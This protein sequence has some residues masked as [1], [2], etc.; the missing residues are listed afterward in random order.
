HPLSSRGVPHRSDLRAAA[1]TRLGG[2][3]VA[4]GGR[5]WVPL[6]SPV[7]ARTIPG[8][9]AN[10]SG[11]RRVHARAKGSVGAVP[12]HALHARVDAGRR[13]RSLRPVMATQH[14]LG[15]RMRW[16]LWSLVGVKLSATS[17]EA[18]CVLDKYF[19]LY[20]FADCTV[21]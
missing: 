15:G 14:Q 2:A 11:V 5:G 4:P 13:T 10:R 20:I 17:H 12:H 18:E 21:Q 6:L 9:R 3:V 16:C 19:K 8:Q 1:A 7:R